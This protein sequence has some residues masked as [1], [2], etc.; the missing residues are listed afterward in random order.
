MGEDA[1]DEHGGLHPPETELPIVRELVQEYE[2]AQRQAAGGSRSRDAVEAAIY[3]HLYMFFSRYYE[4]GD[5]I[6]KRRYSRNQRYAIPYN[7]EEV[8]LHWANSDQYYVK[9]D[10]HFR[11]YDWKAP[12]GVS[13]HFRL[14]NADVEQNNVKGDRRFFIPRISETA[15]DADGN[16]ITI[17]FEYRP[18]SGGETTAYGTRNQ[19]ERIIGEALAKI[20]ERLPDNAPAIAAL[21]G[22][23]RRNGD[24]PVSRLEH[25]LRRYVGRNNSDFFIHRDLSGFLNRELDFYLKNEV[26]NLDSLVAAGQDLTEGWFQQMRLTKAVGSQII[27]FLAQIENFQK[28]LWEK[29]KFVTETQ[30]CITMRN[31]PSDFH[32]DIAAN[33]SQWEEWRELYGIDTSNRSGAF[34]K[35]NPTLVLDTRHFDTRFTDRLPTSFDDLNDMTDGLLL[36]GD[37][38]QTIKLIEEKY[39]GAIQCVYLDPPYNSK[40]TEILYKNQYKHSSWLSLMENRLKAT[41]HLLRKSSVLTIAIDENEQ[42]RLAFLLG[43]L[44]PTHLRTCVTVVHN[45]GGIQGDNFSY[46]NEFAYTIYPAGSR[47]V[48]MQNRDDSPDIRPLRDVST[49]QHLRVDAANC[50]YPIYVKDE[51]V[52][53]FGDVCNEDF[54]PSSANLDVGDGLVAVYPIDAQGNERKWVFSRQNV[55]KI[56]DELTVQW[57]NSRNIWDIIRRKTVFNYKTVWDDRRYNANSHGSK[58]VS[59]LF[60]KR[61]FSFP[62]SVFTVMDS[63]QLATDPCGS[64]EN[65]L[66]YFAGS[67]TTGHAVINLNREDRGE[68]KFILVEMGE[69]FDTVLLPRIKKV[70]FSPEWRDGRPRRQATAEET[71]RSPRII[72]YLRLESYEDALDSIQFGEG[73]GQQPLPGANDEYLLHYML[74]WETRDSETLLNPVLLSRP[75]SY[76][77]R[78]HINGEQ[79]ERPV[80][81]PETFNYLLGL[82]VWKRETYDDNG[83]CYL[84]YRGE[85]RDA[86]GRKVVVIWRE[87]EGWTEGDFARDRDFVDRHAITGDAD[88]VY[89]NGGSCILNA[90]PIEPMFKARMFAGVND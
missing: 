34:L 86:P 31:I 88:R 5:F 27:D 45:P 70:T 39:R 52:V 47:S 4:E 8:Y 43:D 2:E 84:V 65:V 66:D 13:V 26:L 48:G 79:Q 23:H 24:N 74:G 75:F 6:S 37:N 87:T 36:H 81:V 85:T 1:I 33:D 18:L 25:H 32:N 62:K 9:T 82:N 68:R 69:Y 54:H 42:E 73:T 71:E 59:D 17:P 77:L 49:G 90:K 56:K 12:N 89:V 10:E 55:E 53:G 41:R 46:N 58:L 22:E 7:G 29:R 15:W 11:N 21:T 38:W 35:N 30:Y 64:S 14:K 80:D 51:N 78:V 20:P 67:G 61:A 3:N 63:V 40:S 19:Q 16:A 83:R 76:R 60:G 57:N 44:F 50:F 72:K 28:M